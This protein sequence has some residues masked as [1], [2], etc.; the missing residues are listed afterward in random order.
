LYEATDQTQADILK[1]SEAL[2]LCQLELAQ[3]RG[4]Q[5]GW[6]EAFARLRTENTELSARSARIAGT[7]A[8]SRSEAYWRGRGR[9]APISLRNFI[10]TRWPLLR[11]LIGGTP[12]PEVVAEMEQVSLI[13]ASPAFD[14]RWYLEQNPDVVDAG[15]SPALHY[16]QAGGREG[17]DPGP[18]FDT[19]AYRRSHPELGSDANPLLDYLQSRKI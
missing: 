12:P 5:E 9:M 1:L 4:Q 11:K 3:V 18:H 2:R 14:A 17:R 15:I 10:A 7:L 8:N 6:E 13:E 19:R 16:L